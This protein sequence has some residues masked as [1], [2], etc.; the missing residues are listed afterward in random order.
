M[1]KKKENE[2]FVLDQLGYK[3]ANSQQDL[4]PLQRRF[5]LLMNEKRQRRDEQNLD[6]AKNKQSNDPIKKQLR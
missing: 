6:G 5:L 2:G 3:L 4:T 1:E